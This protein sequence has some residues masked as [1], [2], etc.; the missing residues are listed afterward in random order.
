MCEIRKI[1]RSPWLGED[2]IAWAPK[3]NSI[4]NVR[5][6]YRLAADEVSV[7]LITSSGSN[8]DGRRGGWR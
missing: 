5:S 3:K 2:F 1:R 6:T 8:H 4:F 7:P